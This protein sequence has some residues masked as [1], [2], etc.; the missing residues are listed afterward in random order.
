MSAARGL[1]AFLGNIGLIG[2]STFAVNLLTTMAIAAATDYAI[3]ILGR[4]HEAR[5]A[6]EDRETAFYTMY[7]G[8]AHVIP[9][10]GSDDRGCDVLPAFH[11]DAVFQV[12]RHPIGDRNA[13][14]CLRGVDDGAGH[15]DDLQPLRVVRTKRKMRT[16]GWRRIGTAVVRWV[17]ILVASMALALVGLIALPSYTTSYNDRNYLPKDLPANEGLR[18]RG[19]AL[20]AGA[21]ES[22]NCFDRDRSRRPQLRGHAGHRPHAKKIFKVPGIGR[23]Q[24]SRGRWAR[25]SITRRFRSS[26][27]CRAAPSS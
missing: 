11:S 13:D 27:A 14:R 6:G 23:V 1:V 4:Y 8:T 17:P 9:R 3:F 18:R 26:S 22:L 5:E 20:P 15:A 10:L 2:L 21:D 7:H 24:G 16:R 19:P 12:A 25:R